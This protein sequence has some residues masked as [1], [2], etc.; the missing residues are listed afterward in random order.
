MTNYEKFRQQLEL[1]YV[2][3]FASD[4]DY[5]YAA[6]RNTPVGLSDKMTHGL[7]TGSANHDGT[8]IKRACKAVGVKHTR[9]AIREYLES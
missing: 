8:G 9:K 7:L 6:A 4:P 5:S 3:L 1:A 2:D